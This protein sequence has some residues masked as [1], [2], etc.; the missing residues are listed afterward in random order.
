LLAFSGSLNDTGSIYLDD[1]NLR[2]VTVNPNLKTSGFLVTPNPSSG[3]ISIQFYPE[4]TDLRSI[5]LF[6]ATGQRIKVISIGQQATSVYTM[7]LSSL[8]SGVYIVAAGFSN[9]RLVKK[10]IKK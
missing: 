6:S 5:E 4:P 2:R 8:S 9:K 1:V 10:I 3:M 7:D